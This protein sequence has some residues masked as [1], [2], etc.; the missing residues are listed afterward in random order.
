MVHIELIAIGRLKNREIKA[1]CED[2]LTR[3]G[4]F[5]KV[6]LTV[7]R[8]SKSLNNQQCRAEESKKIAAKLNRNSCV[9]LLDESGK[10]MGSEALSN[11]LQKKTI[12]GQSHFSFVL[13]GADGLDDSLKTGPYQLLSLSK[14]TFTHE[15]ARLL[16]LEQLYRAMSI[17]KGTPYHRK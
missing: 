13:G 8:D 6:K 17:W 3:L 1:L 14:M 5:A 15:M 12:Q 16:V 7:I 4:R 9:V 2:Y 11:W 10:Q